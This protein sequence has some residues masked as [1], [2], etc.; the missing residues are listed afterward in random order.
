MLQKEHRTVFDS[1]HK[2]VSLKTITNTILDL[3]QFKYVLFNL[4][5]TALKA[6]YRRSFLGFLWSLLNPLFTMLILSIVFSTIYKL[7]FLEFGLYIM[8]G[9]LPWNLISNGL[10]GGSLAYINAE[11][12]LKKVY[13]PKQIFPI[14]VLGVELVNFSLSLISLL[15]VALVFGARFYWPF[16]LLPVAL[17]LLAL[18]L[19]G[20]MLTISIVTVYFRDFSHILQI[21]LTGLFYLTPVVYPLSFVSGS[22]L[23]RLIIFNPFYYFVEMFHQVITGSGPLS[24]HIW[25]YCLL[26][27][28]VS[29]TVGFF[30][31]L[32]KENDII[33]RL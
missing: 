19:F 33:Y 13:L 5:G 14:S 7:P 21:G 25:F 29:L 18:F 23:Q 30:I 10:V 17:L 11:G 32:K 9:L 16:L 31:F 3:F 1:Q 15:I 26:L 20:L 22:T 2:S 6:R 12:Y 28:V 8:S 24:P 27:S 4:I